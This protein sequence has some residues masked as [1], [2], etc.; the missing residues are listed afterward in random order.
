MP[1]GCVTRP[2]WT[3]RLGGVALLALMTASTAGQTVVYVRA[4]AAGG[5]GTSWATAF[6]DLQDGLASATAAGPGTQLWV[7]QGTY[8]PSPTGDRSA[9]FV[10][11]EGIGL[12]GGFAGTETSLGD[13]DV[14]TNLTTL[15]GDIG[16]PA[17]HSDN[18]YHVLRCGAVGP[19]TRIDGV[20]ITLGRGG[21]AFPDNY[22]AALFNDG[23]SPTLAHCRFISNVAQSGG[24]VFN[25]TA[26]A[27]LIE[28]CTFLMNTASF[29]GGA[30]YNQLATAE[31]IN[32]TFSENWADSDGG[33]LAGYI[34]AGFTLSGCDFL[35]NVAQFN[36]GGLYMGLGS[37]ASID[38]CSFVGDAVFNNYGSS[39]YGG[40]AMYLE[41]GTHTITQCTLTDHLAD[42]NGGGIYAVDANLSMA[43]CTLTRSRA[44]T[45]GG[46][47]HLANT[48]GR[49]VNC[50][51][52]KNIAATG[53]GGFLNGGS[54][55]LTNVLFAGN[56]ATQTGGAFRQL[57]GTANL[58][59]G[60]V[61]HNLAG[62]AA[63]GIMI[64]SGTLDL[65]NTILW[66]NTTGGVSD[67]SAQ[68][69]WASTP[70]VVHHSCIQGYTGSW[71]GAGVI[72]ADP[73]FLDGDGPDGLPGNED[74]D[75]RLKW[76]SPCVETADNGSVGTDELDLDDDGN[77]LEP[78]PTDLADRARVVEAAGP[79]PF[80]VPTGVATADMGA[81][82]LP[83]IF[84]GDFDQDDDVDAA[85]RDHLVTCSSGPAIPQN[86]VACLDADLDAD[87]DV[88][89]TDF[90]WFQLCVGLADE[91]VPQDCQP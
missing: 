35:D 38:T 50:Q 89:Q 61:A 5:D 28:E 12:Y 4:G 65:A 15:S 56:Q 58:T 34:T 64:T 77:V 29:R 21:S 82:E 59:H 17:A 14:E 70:P 10:L 24:A 41:G 37:N 63:G 53:A 16:S 60:T 44:D 55:T 84:P 83:R 69:S 57:A 78:T 42:G 39:D 80:S 45:D 26:A 20:T 19:T 3:I 36:G 2:R 49:I 48:T 9:S 47:F 52:V 68:I 66:N 11:T 30:I 31:V 23:G 74:D 88:D 33:A 32:C 22:G 6:G 71:A 43:R 13:R 81:Y 90:G 86:L 76:I 73:M 72:A 91:P 87:T 62:T 27:P 67:E 8:T 40:G 46:G 7:A 85:D 51:F 79:V 75:L 18:S 1:T 25:N 54:L